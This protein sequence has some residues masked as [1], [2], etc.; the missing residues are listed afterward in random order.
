MKSKAE[1]HQE[2]GT[3]QGFPFPVTSQNFNYCRAELVCPVHQQTQPQTGQGYAAEVGGHRG[4]KSFRQRNEAEHS[5]TWE[6][7]ALLSGSVKA[8]SESPLQCLEEHDALTLDRF[9]SVLF[10]GCRKRNV[11]P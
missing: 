8:T 10:V 2:T 11:P 6:P 7:L 1:G 9:L 5:G 4:S 3:G